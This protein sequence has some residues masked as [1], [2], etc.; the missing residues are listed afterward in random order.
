[1]NSAP[2]ARCDVLALSPFVIERRLRFD[3][4]SHGGVEVERGSLGDGFEMAFHLGVSSASL[5]TAPLIFDGASI[6]VESPP[7]G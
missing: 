4:R 7:F 3:L 2:V 6:C 1:M 5:P